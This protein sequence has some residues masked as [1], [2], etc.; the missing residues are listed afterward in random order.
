MAHLLGR[1][2]IF[3]SFKRVAYACMLLV[4]ATQTPRSPRLLKR[5]RAV[6]D[7]RDAPSEAR[8]DNRY[9]PD[10]LSIWWCKATTMGD[11][12]PVKAGD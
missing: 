4:C 12:A 2:S 8:P 9:P 1:R 10:A 3:F 11:Y 5:R 7:Q 6:R